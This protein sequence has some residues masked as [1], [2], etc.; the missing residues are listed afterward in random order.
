MGFNYE[1]IRQKVEQG[2]GHQWTSYSDLFLVLSVTFLLLY[3]VVS[4][5]SGTSS[6]SRQKIVAEVADLKK[7][8]N[9]YEVLKDDYLKNGASAE[10]V[11][12][13][14]EMMK[15]LEYMQKEAKEEN[16]K[17]KLQ[18]REALEREQGLNRT[19]AMVKSIVNANLIS[20]ARL[21]KRDTVIEGQ[22]K[23]LETLDKAVKEKEAAI[24]K[25]TK[26]IEQVQSDLE[27]K[28]KA[29][30]QAYLANH[31]TKAK[32]QTEL[33]QLETESNAKMQS[34]HEQSQREISNLSSN[35]QA[36]MKK[37]EESFQAGLKNAQLSA[38]AKVEAERAHRAAVEA[39][40]QKYQSEMGKLNAALGESQGKLS[41]LSQSNS[42]LAQ[43]NQGLQKELNASLEKLNAQRKLAERI[44]SGFAKAG[45]QADV[46]PKT[47][48]VTV[49]FQ[50]EYFDTDRSLLK[51]GMKSTLEKMV[52]IYAK[53]LFQDPT[54]VKK[55]SSVEIVGYASPTYKGKVV[56]PKSLTP[57]DRTAVNYNMDLSYK[58]AKSIFEYVFDPN[59]IKFDHQKDL[60]PFVKVS[61]RSY[62]SSETSRGP[63]SSDEYRKSQIVLIKFNLKEK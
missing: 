38:A 12:M 5:R 24:S 45:I 32:Y 36:N 52:P 49:H 8:L 21:H 50:N 7:Q 10:E 16:E 30:K 23:E 59:R 4:L 20:S 25:N 15:S 9:A 48:D 51:P 47:G 53:S 3:V 18:A 34:L 37:M 27:R 28:S 33:A 56:D 55:I 13:Y 61:G 14:Q 54:I 35:H 40:N 46:D 42:A 26:Q 41:A 44:K 63:S 39:Q 58:R 29:L 11:A 60:L 1:K 43:S 19:Q 2:T 31:K 17:L 62:L 22:S 6:F 57:Q